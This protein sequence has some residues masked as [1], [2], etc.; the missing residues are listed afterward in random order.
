MR[1]SSHASPPQCLPNAALGP[2]GGVPEEIE[3]HVDPRK[4]F[5]S[6]EPSL[7]APLPIILLEPPNSRFVCADGNQ[8]RTSHDCDIF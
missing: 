6:S 1:T 8:P 7:G 5:A 3:P 2:M 4:S